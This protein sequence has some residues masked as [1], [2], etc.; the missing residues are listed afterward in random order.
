MENFGAFLKE[1]RI[2]KNLRLKDLTCSNI[3]E[4]TISRF[5]NGLTKLSV[6]H[7][8]MLLQRLGITFT[9]FEELLHCYYS[10][11]E[12]LFQELKDAV[13]ASDK[14]LLQQLL[15]KIESRQKYEKN[16]CND[17]IK[18][19]VEQ[20]M[21]R[22]ANLSYNEEKC[23]K[24]ITYLLTVDNWME[25]ELKLFYHSVFFMKPKTIQL[26]Y[27]VVIKKTRHFLKTDYGMHKMIPI[28][29]FNLELLLQNHLWT[30][31]RFFIDDLENLLTRPG[32]YFEKNYLLF[33]RG[34]YHL[35]TNQ[36]TIGEQ[37]CLKALKIFKEYHDTAI[38]KKLK[39]TFDVT[40]LFQE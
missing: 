9:E 21:N 40:Y 6:D 15:I 26:L 5:E 30:N 7:F 36:V 29:L 39:N 19:I 34:V 38:L 37:E 31:A 3:S 4:A 24:L 33:L 22:L 25:Q 8:Y 1:I 28:Y 27:R 14:L 32:Y 16:V 18:I 17:Y 13:T 23:R 11:H 10:K 35:K 12:C 2:S 20:H